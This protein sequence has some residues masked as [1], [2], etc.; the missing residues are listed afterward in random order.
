M[1]KRLTANHALKMR[2]ITIGFGNPLLI[3]SFD[4]ISIQIAEL[5]LLVK[6][7]PGALLS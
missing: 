7:L 2:L 6:A 5:Q 3:R 4:F 1:V